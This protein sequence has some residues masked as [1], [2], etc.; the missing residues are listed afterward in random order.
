MTG[1]QVKYTY[2]EWL[3]I[4]LLYCTV[5]SCFMGWAFYKIIME[6]GKKGRCFIKYFGLYIDAGIYIYYICC[7]I[8][9]TRIHLYDLGFHIDVSLVFIIFLLL[10]WIKNLFFAW[11]ID[12]IEDDI[13][14]EKLKIQKI[15][16]EK[17]D[18]LDEMI[19]NY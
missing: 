1:P 15:A 14:R 4:P 12:E 13:L 18:T 6:E 19:T 11:R 7:L 2:T 10:L 5:H 9:L 8:K 3:K 16:M 17:D